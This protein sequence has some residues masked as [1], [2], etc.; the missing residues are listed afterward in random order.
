MSILSYSEIKPGK[1]ILHNDEPCEVVEYHVARTQQ[2]KPQN[3]TK[4]RSLISGKVFPATFHVSDQ[5]EEADVSKR[6]VKFLYANRGEFWFCDPTN[7]ANRFKLEE[8]MLG[9]SVKFLKPNEIASGLV[10]TNDDDEE[11]II[12]IKLPVKMVFSIK[13]VAPQIKGSTATGGNKPATLE[14]GAVVNVPMFVNEGDKILV[15]TETGE[16]VERA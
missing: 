12:S 6:D 13:E 14:N 11:K 7:P 15:N 1:I 2:R 3:Q 9:N 16:Y 5:A 8:K 4:L 10:F